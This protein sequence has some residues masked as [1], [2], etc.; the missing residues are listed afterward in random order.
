MLGSG[1]RSIAPLVNRATSSAIEWNSS[2][3]LLEEEEALVGAAGAAD[4][5][6]AAALC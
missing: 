3:P 5:E 6:A 1:L 4:D 2:V